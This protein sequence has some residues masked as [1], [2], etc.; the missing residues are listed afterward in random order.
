MVSEKTLWQVYIPPLKEINHP[1]YDVT[2]S[3]E[4]YQFD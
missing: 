2:K 3:K 1:Q 4:Q